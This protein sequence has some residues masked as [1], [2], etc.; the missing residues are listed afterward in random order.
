MGS[1]KVRLGAYFVLMSLLPLG[2]LV[3]GFS[4]LE[5]KNETQ[6]VDARLQAGLRASLAA[7]D[8]RVR[9]AQSA[10]DALARSR[11][12]QVALERHDAVR[13]RTLLR[14]HPDLEV[15]APGIRVGRMQVGAHRRVAVLVR[16]RLAGTV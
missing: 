2:A 14:G 3:W 6:R 7:Y 15:N 8:D 10:A 11:P 1:F 9:A 16:G 5:A 4:S 12:F 13:V